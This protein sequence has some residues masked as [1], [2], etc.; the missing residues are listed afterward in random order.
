M[1]MSDTAT[2]PAG[3]TSALSADD[4]HAFATRLRL[5]P[6]SLAAPDW[7]VDWDDAP[8]SV[9]VYESGR[10]L[11]LGSRDPA[12]AAAPELES[13]GRMLFWS[14]GMIRVR[15]DPHGTLPPSPQR[16]TVTTPRGRR[17][18][19]RRAIPSG[20]AA[21]PTEAYVVG[22]RGS[23]GV[24]GAYHYDP[25]RHELVDLDH[26]AAMTALSR[27]LGMPP[28]A[29]VARLALVLTNRFWKNVFKYGDF[30]YRLGSVDVGV[31]LG[32]VVR[33]GR[34][35]FGAVDVRLDFADR[36]LNAL[37]GLDG[38]EESAYAVVGLGRQPVDGV[39]VAAATRVRPSP[40]V[41]RERSTDVRRS[42]PFDAMHAA[43]SRPLAASPPPAP[44]P[45]ETDDS[46]PAVDGL[47]RLPACAP[48]D[49]LDPPV[50]ARRSSNGDLFTG[51]S[52]EP[53]AVATVLEHTWRAL[54]ALLDCCADALGNGPRLYCAVQRVSDIASGWYRYLPDEHALAP[55][56]TGRSPGCGR[57]LQEALYAATVN[58]ELAAF[59]VHV[60]APTD[61]RRSD[62]QVRDYRVQQMLVGVAVEAITVAS[63]A[64]RLGSHPLLGFDARAVD[65]AYGLDGSGHGVHAEVCVGRARSGPFLQGRVIA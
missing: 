52:V 41:V 8:W 9:K 58:M 7:Q 46:E 25:Y 17:L 3:G 23:Y 51:A 43:A 31:A 62:R 61:F 45:L 55:V 24:S 1:N 20:G 2:K 13:L 53:G 16:P 38:I 37:L 47:C 21:Y 35:L 32:R 36:H 63:A 22:D 60:T 49:L 6:T 59:T 19:P 65:S 50:L 27:A 48:L 34:A 14:L 11:G 10:R 42:A 4:A 33:A 28:G 18:V 15:W 12:V 64:V 30:A 29:G 5:H 26:P 54:A 56:G 40:P 44:L 57:L 39:K